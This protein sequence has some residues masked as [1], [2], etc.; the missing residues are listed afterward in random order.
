[1]C[2]SFLLARSLLFPIHTVQD[3]DGMACLWLQCQVSQADYS[4]SLDPLQTNKS[5][6]VLG[7][8]L[9]APVAATEEQNPRAFYSEYGASGFLSAS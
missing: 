3:A 6:P 2:V 5:R 7:Q 1:M 8:R 4:A 9:S